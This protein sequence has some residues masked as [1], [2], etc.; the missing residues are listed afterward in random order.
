[1]ETSTKTK[2]KRTPAAKPQ[3]ASNGSDALTVLRPGDTGFVERLVVRG[4]TDQVSP[5]L[6]PVLQQMIN[7]GETEM[8][9]LAGKPF[10]VN[11]VRNWSYK[12][13]TLLPT[14][15]RLAI[16]GGT[17]GKNIGVTI[18]DRKAKKG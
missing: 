4:R 11:Q 2:A 7:D 9:L 15:K 12:A 3:A 13:I 16:S 18:V 8:Q 5:V 17:E 10:T 1:M 6:N 14:G